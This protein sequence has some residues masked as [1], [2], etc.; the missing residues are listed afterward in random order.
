[1]K[2]FSMSLAVGLAH[3]FSCFIHYLEHYKEHKEDRDREQEKPG[4]GFTAQTVAAF[5]PAGGVQNSCICNLLYNLINGILD[6]NIS[7]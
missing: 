7:I 5:I 1:M 2:A 4:L 6:V 3:L